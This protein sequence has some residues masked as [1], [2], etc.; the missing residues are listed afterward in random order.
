MSGPPPQ[1][2]G[3]RDQWRS[4]DE[5]ADAAAFRAATADEFA[6]DRRSMLRAFGAT[7]ALA[8]LAGCEARPDERARPY[9]TDPENEIPGKPRLYA[10]AVPFAG[11]AQPVIGTTHTGRPTKLEGNP[12]HPASRGATDAFTQAALLDLYDPERSQAPSTGGRPASWTDLDAALADR[13]ALS[14]ANRGE[15][16]CLLTG[17]VTSPTLLRQLRRLLERWPAARWH[18]FEPVDDSARHAAAAQAFGRPLDVISL[19]DRAQAVVACDAD[20]LGPGPCQVRDSLAWA[21]RRRAFQSGDGAASLMV[22]EPSPTLT[23]ARSHDRLAIEAGRIPLLIGALARVFGLPSTVAPLR[24]EEQRWVERAARLLAARRGQGLVLVGADQPAEVQALGWAI[25]ERLGNLGQ[26]SRFAPP[27]CPSPPPDRTLAALLAEMEAGRVQTLAIL[28]ANPLYASPLGPAFARALGKVPF[29]LHAGLWC[30][31]TGRA[32]TWHA[33]LAHPLESWSDGRAA[34]GSAVIGQPLV[35]PLYP[36]RPLTAMLAAIGGEFGASDH[37]LVRQTWQEAWGTLTQWD[38]ALV[39]GIAPEPPATPLPAPKGRITAATPATAPDGLELLVRP[40]PTVWDGRLANNPWAQEL[41]KPVTTLTWDNAVL[42][43]PA[44]A[45]RLGVRDGDEVTLSRGGAA[46]TG[47]VWIVPGQ[48][49]RTVLVH[50]GYGRRFGAVAK[51]AGFDVTGLIGA[52]GEVSLKP[53]GKRRALAAAQEQQVI[54]QGD[55][56]PVRIVDRLDTAPRPPAPEPPSFWPARP[57]GR[58]AWG[59]SIDLD[60]CT[61]C[62]ACVTACNAENN[63]PMVGREAV[64]DGRR[65][66]WLRIDRYFEGPPENPTLHSQPVPCMQCEDAPCEMGCPVNASVHS[67]EGLNL[68]VYNRCIGTRTC[69]SYCPYKVR[70]FNWADYQGGR[71]EAVKAQRN[72]NVTVRARGVMEKCTYCIQRI[73]AARIAAKLAGAPISDGAVRTACQQVCPTGAISFGDVADPASEVSRRKAG[74]RDYVLLEEANTRPRTSYLARI[75]SEGA[76]G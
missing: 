55:E 51:G 29:S 63:V 58:P 5:L 45:T 26:T 68:Q 62:G 25:D 15:G 39:K 47:A 10:T 4:L 59:M 60:L 53:T 36:V 57:A 46:V 20:P 28:E 32:C 24:P 41:P 54:A 16:L 34:D 70:R 66:H 33:P 61:G 31:E 13:T 6:L 71:P 3:A 11:I 35:Q 19:L 74:P 64:R 1:A 9:V 21:A 69:S 73:S 42:V 56:A 65:M 30:D 43:A 48:A 37:D 52:S 12:D 38:E 67:P 17:A 23:G 2:Q 8:G 75:R 7:L 76:D 72:P 49:L 18:V 44:L 27:L 22:A 40:D 50:R 14:A